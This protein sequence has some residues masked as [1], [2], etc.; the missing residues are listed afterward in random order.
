MAK[1]GEKLTPKQEAFCKAYIETGSA[2]AA[3]RKAFDAKRM[4][5]TG[6]NSN[7]KK[8]LKRTPITLRIEQ[9]QAGH[10]KRHGTTVD[11]LIDELE[12]ARALAHEIETPATAITAVMS[13]AKLLGF[14]VDKTEVTG[15]GGGPIETKDA[16]FDP[17]AWLDRAM[18]D[19]AAPRA[20]GTHEAPPQ[21]Q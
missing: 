8:L 10:L 16:S 17:Q 14:V 11:S 7:A 2:S 19:K 4:K 6:V 1:K 3:Y 15:K 5:A 12:K 20:N 18:Q 9:L 21:K 13:K